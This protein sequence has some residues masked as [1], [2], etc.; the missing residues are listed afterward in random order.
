MIQLSMSTTIEPY[1]QLPLQP[2]PDQD[3]FIYCDAYDIV[4]DAER[5]AMES[6]PEGQDNLLFARVAGFLLIE[7]FDKRAILSVEPC[8]SLALEIVS[9]PLA[10][11]TTHDLVFNL[12]KQYYDYF[13]FPCTSGSSLR[14]SP[15][16]SL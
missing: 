4:L 2:T 11:T 16:H 10:G 6:G 12:G 9:S 5:H 13:I 8:A 7:F 1:S 3:W 15:S 14:R